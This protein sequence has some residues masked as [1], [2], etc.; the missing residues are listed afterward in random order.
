[1]RR[2]R[3]LRKISWQFLPR[4]KLLP[5]R[6]LPAKRRKRPRPAMAQHRKRLLRKHRQQGEIRPLQ[7]KALHHRDAVKKLRL[8]RLP[9]RCSRRRARE[10]SGRSM[11]RISKHCS[12][13]VRPAMAL[14]RGDRPTSQRRISRMSW[15]TRSRFLA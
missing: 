5:R 7:R 1:L 4:R 15:I 8:T 2:N 9:A 12:I 13:R 11:P 10:L 14:G 3:L 6:Q